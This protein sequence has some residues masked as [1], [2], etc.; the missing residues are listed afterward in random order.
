ML[1]RTKSVRTVCAVPL[2]VEVQA[3]TAPG[4]GR[5]LVGGQQTV[6]MDVRPPDGASEK[7]LPRAAKALTNCGHSYNKRGRRA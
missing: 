6:L 2:P 5:P 1:V 7:D 3:L 4:N